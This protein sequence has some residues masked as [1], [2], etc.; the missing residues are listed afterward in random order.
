MFCD[1]GGAVGRCFVIWEGLLG[2]AVGRCF[3]IWEGLLEGV[4]I[5]PNTCML[6]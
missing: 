5:E 3:V 4:L 6:G 2:G 1:L